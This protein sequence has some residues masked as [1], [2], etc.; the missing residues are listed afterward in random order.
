MT[1]R[2]IN[3]GTSANKGDGDSLRTAFNTI[4]QNFSYLSSSTSSN[5]GN[6]EIIDQVI[7]GTQLNGDIS[8][9][10]NGTGSVVVS[11]LTTPSLTIKELNTS[12]MS[13]VG[14]VYYEQG[15]AASLVPGTY[16]STGTFGIPYAVPAPY[17]V[18]SAIGDSS[19][20]N[21]ISV[22]DFC[23][24]A[25]SKTFPVL[26]RGTGFYQNYI[27]LDV[28]TFQVG[29]EQSNIGT[30][31]HV[32]RALNRISTKFESNTG[33]GIILDCAN[34]ELQVR[35]SIIPF[36][37][38][39]FQT[40]GM[41]TRRWSDI[42]IGTGGINLED[43]VDSR[44]VKIS[45]RNGNL[46]LGKSGISVGSLIIHDDYISATT[47]TKFLVGTN[48]EILSIGNSGISLSS[49][50][51]I[52]FGDGTIQTTANS[53]GT[54]GPQGP[55]GIQ[56]PVGPQGPIGNT[57]PQGIQG[58]VGSTGTQGIQGPI[59]PQ[60]SKGD[61]GDQ[62]PVGSTGTQGIQGPTGPQGPKGDIGDQGPVGNTGTQ[63]IQGPT[64]PQGPKGD[65]GDQG[66]VGSTGTQGIQGPT[67]PQGPEGP[68]GPQGL[69]GSTGT[70]GP[71]GIQGE[72]GPQGISVSLVGTVTN[73][74]SLPPSADFGQ[75]YITV[76]TGD[77]WFWG[78]NTQW[79]NVGQIVGP[80]GPQGIQGPKGDTGNQGPAGSTGT[81]GIQGPVGPQ[82]PKGDTGNQGPIGNTG[83]QGVQGPVGPEG[84]QGPQGPQGPVGSTGTQGI[85]GPVGPQGPKGDT[86][87]QGP[88]G[89]TGTQGI[90]GPTG[91][92]GPKG[93][94][95][96]Q[97]PIGNT[98]T[99]GIQGPTGPQGTPGVD[100]NPDS[101]ISGLFNI[102]LN[103]SGHFIPG[104]DNLQ[105]IGS[106][107]NRFRHL[108][109]GPGSVTIGDSV[110]TESTTGKLVLPGVTRATSTF[111]DEI[112]ETA[113]QI[114]VFGGTPFVTDSYDYSIRAGVETAPVGYIQ[115]EYS[116]DE[117]DDDGYIDGIT[118]DEQGLWT[119]TI[120]DINRRN[121]MYAYVGPNVN[122]PFDVSN[123]VQIP[124]VVRSKANDIEYEFEG[125]DLGDFTI[126]GSTFEADSMSIKTNDG[127]ITLESDSDIFNKIRE[128]GDFTIED[129]E[130]AKFTF[131]PTTGNITFP[132]NTVQTTAYTSGTN[133]NTGNVV[134]DGNQLYVGGTGFLNLENGDDQIEIGSNGES[135]LIISV[136]EGAYR[137]EFGTD[138][139]LSFPGTFPGGA[140]GYDSDTG[141]L[142]LARSLG[143]SLY[144]Q[145][146]AWVFGS[147]GSITF[148]DDTVQT[149]AYTGGGGS[150]SS[151]VVRQDTAPTA[152]NG[153]LWFNT[154][155][156]RLYIK[157]ND[158]W[159]DSNPVIIPY[160]Q[161]ALEVSSI[162][163]PDASV[164][165]SV[166][167][168]TS[169]LTPDR[170][171]NGEY[172][173]VLGSDG[174]LTLP[175]AVVNST[176]AKTGGNLQTPTAIDLTKSINKLTDGEYILANG[177]EGQIMYLVRQTGSAYNAIRV[178]VANARVDGALT[179][180]IDYYP[181]ENISA[182]NMSTLIFTDG[183]WQASNGGW[184]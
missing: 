13:Y 92:Q 85:Q 130:G 140:I 46:K 121:S 104:T 171:V 45:V 102:T 3:T 2:Y 86:G 155:E 41:P 115:A 50:T 21:K 55:Q 57:G 116:V 124:F 172:E 149:T 90:Q 100:A 7:Y 135:P 56:G 38:S 37:N 10:P 170:L 22:G 33:T 184:D 127:D 67:G 93:D 114:Y 119:Q 11:S 66:P 141:T 133:A 132:D 62:G 17:Y 29:D 39:S 107:S 175:G 53:S 109:V 27:V 75:G 181:F 137:W 157:Y 110:I 9:L 64:G 150:G 123:W 34:T 1:I 112:E 77:V 151:T 4:N 51:S 74:L 8:I 25:D 146:G 145:A 89:N 79:N 98:G 144:T 59:G 147:D 87:N 134:F 71:Q 31:V 84:P 30:E 47:S 60:G 182:A 103:A 156:G 180:T 106:L 83:T 111:A 165:T 153:T 18:F 97:G 167:N 61:T 154:V 99:Q 82:G 16:L 63:G 94:T 91:P 65:T 12:T 35:G 54:V 81:Q 20:I 126:D 72:I 44:D 43:E 96:A 142:Q 105:D 131:N 14:F 113:D 161:T 178:N 168:L 183:A 49:G 26:A 5:T 117:I 19:T 174:G 40:L 52:T 139:W 73:S 24:G 15:R 32:T 158:Q 143:V 23:S 163:F 136:N 173:V 162:T 48:T 179:T 128:N 125:A 160:P 138:G 76:D 88:I 69:I 177:V 166:A 118:V 152:S 101:V 6:L 129:A 58:P 108:Y 42:W 169:E 80:Q 122:E 148:P 95:G 176:V 120:A 78:T 70:Q 36:E 159:I 68:Q 164:L 28:S